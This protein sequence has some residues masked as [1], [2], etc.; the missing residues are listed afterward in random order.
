MMFI[1]ITNSQYY[2]HYANYKYT[3]KLYNQ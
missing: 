3:H 1:S 2:K